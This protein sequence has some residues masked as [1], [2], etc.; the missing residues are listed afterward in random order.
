MSDTT[1]TWSVDPADVARFSAIAE[2]WWDPKGKFGPLHVF[3]PIRL[4]F[5]REQV[6]EAFGR[7]GTARQPFTGLK[8]LD[9]GCGGGLLSEPMRRL[10]FTVTAVDASERNIAV[11]STHATAQGLDIDFRAGTAEQLAAEG[12]GPFDVILNMEVIEHVA[13]PGEYLRTTA[14]LLAPGGLM[15]LATLNRTLKALALAKVGAEYI[16]R[17]L[18][19]GTH[20]WNQFLKPEEI[21]TFLA[22]TPYQLEGPFGVSFNP[23]T[24]QWSRSADSDINYMMTVRA[25]V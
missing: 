17:W 25:P 10:G 19:P 11:A 13:D 20:D 2:E 6:L 18:P 9:I 12:A 1:A 5:I 23:L 4:G 16:L 22:G 21:E 15:I 3:N 14:S 7:D 8:L 24:G